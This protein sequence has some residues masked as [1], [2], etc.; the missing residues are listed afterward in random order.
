MQVGIEFEEIERPDML[1][2]ARWLQN[3][4]GKPQTFD[5]R[6]MMRHGYPRLK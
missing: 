3:G 6:C 5:H 4:R 1:Q 2:T